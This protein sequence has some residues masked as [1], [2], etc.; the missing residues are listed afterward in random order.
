MAFHMSTLGSF[1]NSLY[2][3]ADLEGYVP[4]AGDKPEDLTYPDE[5]GEFG[6]EEWTLWVSQAVAATER[7]EAS[8]K[9]WRE[10]N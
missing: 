7:A 2:Q 3:W 8:L 1:G 6:D 9:R 5:D 4:Q 10:R